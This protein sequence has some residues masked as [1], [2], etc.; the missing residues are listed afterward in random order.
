MSWSTCEFFNQP[1]LNTDVCWHQISLVDNE[2]NYL[3]TSCIINSSQNSFQAE[4]MCI[5]NGMSLFEINNSTV[6]SAFFTSTSDALRDFP[7]GFVWVNGRRD[8]DPDNFWF[9]RNPRRVP[10]YDEI[11]WV[12]TESIDGRNSGDCLRFKSQ[13]GLFRAMGV[14]CSTTAWINCE[15]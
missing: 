11:N 4:Q 8:P 2:G 10:L 13:H 14:A 12:N 1:S 7:G 15:Y 6:Q 9:A 3:K 5:R